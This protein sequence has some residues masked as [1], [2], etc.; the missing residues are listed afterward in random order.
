M[1]RNQMLSIGIT[2]GL[3]GFI[4]LVLI[5]FLSISFNNTILI[6]LVLLDLAVL[7]IGI[8]CILWGIFN[9]QGNKFTSILALGFNIIIFAVLAAS[10]MDLI[11]K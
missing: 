2:L 6:I 1:D 5:F 8:F 3:I 11:K 9:Y 4:L 10:L 7:L